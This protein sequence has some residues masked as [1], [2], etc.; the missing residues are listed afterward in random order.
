VLNGDYPAER[1]EVVVVDNG[2]VTDATERVV[3]E[4]DDHRVRCIREE[5]PG[6][7][8]ARNA[9][10]AFAGGEVLAFTDDD[11]RVDREWLS[12]LA[13]AFAAMPNVGCVTGLI[14]PLEIET[15]AQA[16]IEEF[17]G[18][19]KGFDRR[20]YDLR[21]FRPATPTFPY[22]AG[23]FGSGQN[24]AF[25]AEA[26]R[27]L[28]GFDPAL[29][30]GT[31]ALGGVDIEM[32]FRT[33]VQGYRLV[34]E[35][36][37]IVHHANHREYERL[38]RQVYMYGVGVSAFLAR[39][40]VARPDL[41]RDFLRRVP[42]GVRYALSPASEKNAHRTNRYPREL[43][44]LELIGLVVGPFAYARSRRVMAK[45]RDDSSGEQ[46]ALSA[47]TSPRP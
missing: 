38:R 47:S 34:Y 5:T 14:L 40:L 33:I 37:A 6:S 18:F 23:R 19:S 10:A 7:A 46:N 9:G 1:F 2:S 30:N 32:F 15:P 36:R 12:S 39:S 21:D 17:G 43:R 41:L 27:A 31:P 26:F 25:S 42:S 13:E 11:T 44:W 28:G 8:S 45:S 4:F 24:M 20:V 29:G 35:P 3:E 22:S 16:L